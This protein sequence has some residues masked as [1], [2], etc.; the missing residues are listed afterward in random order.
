MRVSAN[1]LSDTLIHEENDSIGKF[2]PIEDEIDQNPFHMSPE[3]QLLMKK[4]QTY[5]Q[6]LSKKMVM[7]TSMKLVENATQIAR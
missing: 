2:L 6:D 7:E 4:Q 3:T 5:L 1:N